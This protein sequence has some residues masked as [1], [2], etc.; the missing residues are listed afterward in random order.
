MGGDWRAKE[1]NEIAR[2]LDEGVRLAG[3]DQ[4][5]DAR[6]L[7]SSIDQNANPDKLV[8]TQGQAHVTVDG[9]DVIIRLGMPSAA[10]ADRVFDK[11]VDQYEKTG[12]I[13]LFMKLAE[14]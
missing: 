11:I 5:I 2:M 10:L 14:H 3:D 12:K 1:D 13:T 8:E 6:N 7:R 9:S 4:R